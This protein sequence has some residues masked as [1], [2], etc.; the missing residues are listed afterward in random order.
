[1]KKIFN[2]LKN[3]KMSLLSALLVVVAVLLGAS[4]G[5]AMAVVE[6]VEPAADPNPSE[7]IEPVS[8]SN[9]GGRPAGEAVK[10]DEQGNLTQLPGQPS[11]ATNLRDAGLMAEDYDE[12]TVEFRKFK[13]PEELIIARVCKPVKAKDY[14]HNHWVDGSSDLDSVYTG[15]SNITITYNSN[16]KTISI[17]KEDLENWE[18]LINYSDVVIEGVQGYT[19]DEAGNQIADG[20]LTLFVLDNDFQGEK[21]KF[22][23]LNPPTASGTTVTIE[24]TAIFHCMATAASESQMNVQSSSFQPA[25]GQC[26][27]QKKIET[28]VVTE[29]FEESE[30]KMSWKTRNILTHA[31]DNFKRKC[32]R[33]HWN[34]KQFHDQIDV[35][36]TNGR[37]SVFHEKGMLR[38]IPILYTHGNEMNDDDFLAITTLMFTNNAT[39]DHA[40]AFCGKKEL[41][42]II[43]YA[44]S[45]IKHKD[46]GKVEVNKFGIKIRMYEDNFGSLEFIWSQTLDDLGYT[47]YMAVLDLENAERPYLKPEERKERDMSKTGEA[48]EAKEYNLIRI[49]CVDLLG[50]NAVLACPSQAAAAKAAKIGSIQATFEPVNE[51]PTA[52]EIAAD[53]SLKLKKYFLTADDDTAGFKAGDI[54]EWDNNLED[55]KLF[56][57]IV[58]QVA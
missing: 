2:Y 9:P 47:E 44:N 4:S 27:L 22:K 50:H 6:P 38:Q 32:A 28:V 36:A 15:D 12:K 23:V 18:I 19:K 56:E 11:S 26:F 52:E 29:R 24:P 10:P 3:H 57:G 39:N 48:R 51:L 25:P 53:A 43:K 14:V 35:K 55:W 20:E 41:K 5:F 54:V 37:E 21:I 13:Y 8:E 30:T 45:S 33:S 58:G 49:D 46:V 17:D 42:R 16:N 34:G 1:M 7:N 31:K 40:Y